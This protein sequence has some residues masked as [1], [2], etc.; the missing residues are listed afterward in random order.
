MQARNENFVLVVDRRH[1]LG[2]H[3]APRGARRGA[4]GPREGEAG[5]SGAKPPSSVLD[6]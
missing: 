5:G 6:Q 4:K 1:G 3:G 2:A